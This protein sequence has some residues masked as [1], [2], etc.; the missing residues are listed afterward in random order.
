MNDVTAV[1]AMADEVGRELGIE[2]QAFVGKLLG[3]GIVRATSRVAQPLAGAMGRAA[4]R[5]G[6][7]F[8]K[9]PQGWLKQLPGRVEAGL[10]T[11]AGQ[12]GLQRWGGRLATSGVG[13]VGGGA[14]G[15][16]TAGPDATLQER[17]TRAGKGAAIGAGAG[18]VA[19]QAVTQAGR[20]QAKRVAARQRHSITGYMPRTKEQIARGVGKG[21]QGMTEAERMASLKSMGVNT[22]GGMDLAAAE[23]AGH[24]GVQKYLK[25][26]AGEAARRG[27]TSIP[28]FVK[29][30]AK[31]P[32]E[33]AAIGAGSGGLL[34]AG[35]MG[36]FGAMQ[37]PGALKRTRESGSAGN[38][39][40]VIGET[41]GYTLGAPI[42]ILG[43]IALG[44]LGGKVGR[45]V[46]QG[47]GQ[48]T[49]KGQPL[50]QG[51]VAARPLPGQVMPRG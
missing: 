35:L 34:G 25:G 2:K 14:Y 31:N 41:A 17:L 23:A 22:G 47:V 11:E 1:L 20:A 4:E 43:N 36:G 32:M 51:Y 29:E 45:I 24:Q 18:L 40:Q 49:G 13:A 37:V 12:A 30:L 26:G 6:A 28:G 9:Q 46:G 21:G 42:P 5:S 15:A 39:G 7:Q 3:R 38:L 44:S 50:P 10:K 27:M 16:A 48:I 19:G 8:L 33:A